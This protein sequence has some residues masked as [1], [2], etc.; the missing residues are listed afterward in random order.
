MLRRCDVVLLSPSTMSVSVRPARYK[1]SKF[2]SVLS[3]TSN[4]ISSQ[5]SNFRPHF[6]HFSPPNC[7]NV[8]AESNFS[9]THTLN[10]Y[11]RS[12]ISL[13]AHCWPMMRLR[14]THP[15][16]RRTLWYYS[17]I[18]EHSPRWFC[19]HIS[20]RM[21]AHARCTYRPYAVKMHMN[22]SHPLHADGNNRPTCTI[23]PKHRN[24][25]ID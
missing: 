11:W 1:N 14:F 23:A 6:I 10:Y 18:H 22:N 5:R 19:I 20:M 24:R 17:F 12:R 2:F 7:R 25:Q 13:F 15:H 4:T 8:F 3:S 9:A 21:F 16:P